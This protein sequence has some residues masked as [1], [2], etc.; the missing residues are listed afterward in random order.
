MRRKISL[1]IDGRPADLDDQALILFNYTMEDLS[2]PT[3][4][5]NSFSQQVTLPGTP[6]NNQIF[7]EMYRL[8][9]T[10]DYNSGDTGPGFNPSRKTPFAIYNELDEIL[11]SG[12]IK[13]DEVVRKR[14]AVSYKVTLYGGLGSFLF[15][16]S[17][18]EDG[19][20]RTLADLDYLG[21]GDPD[22]LDFTIDKT[23]LEQ[24]W[25][26]LGHLWSGT[27]P[28]PSGKWTVI[29][30][31]PAYNGY[32]D[33]FSPDRGIVQ[34]AGVGLTAPRDGYDVTSGYCL[35]NLANPQD[36]WA[37]KDFRSYLQRPV[38]SVKALFDALCNPDNNGGYS[39]DISSISTPGQFPYYTDIWLTLPTIPSL[40]SMKQDGTGLSLTLTS[41]A[42]TGNEIGRYD[43]VGTIPYGAM[44]NA[45][46]KCKLRFN[47]PAGADSY[48]TLYLVGD[49]GNNLAKSSV[50][51]LQMLAYG[52]DG[53]I[54]GGSSVKMLNPMERD[55]KKVATACGFIPEFATDGYE[56]VDYGQVDKVTA[57]L[58]EVATELAFQVEAQDA[59]YYKLKAYVY[60]CNSGRMRWG[61]WSNNY[62]GSGTSCRA[63]LYDDYTTYF[64]ADTVFIIDGSGNT[65]TKTDPDALRSGAMVT[66][67]MLLSSS[68]TPAEYLLSF[69]K[70]FGLY[71][72]ADT[73]DKKVTIL[74]RNDLYIDETID[75]TERVDTS[76]D[77]EI[78]P[79]LFDS[80]WYRFA[81]EGIG[82]EF[83]DEYRKV[84][85]LDYG[86]QLIDTGFD[87]NADV[88]DLLDTNVFR[89]AVTVL[90]RS[91][92]WNIIRSGGN[93]IPSPFL[94]DGNS[95]SLRDASGETKEFQISRPP[96]TATITYYNPYYNGY[97]IAN[98]TKVQFHDADGKMLDGK[99]VLL[100]LFGFDFYASFKVT[101]DLPVMT[102]LNGGK[103]CWI[104]DEGPGLLIPIFSRY[105]FQYIHPD[106]V[107]A[108]SLDFG[109]PRQLDIP[110]IVYK[111]DSTIY[112]KAWKAYLTDR[113]DVNT[114]VMRCRVHFD[115]IQVGQ[116]LLRKFFFYDNSLWVLNRISN[117][118]LTTYDPVECE[119]IKV[120]DKDNYLTGQDY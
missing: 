53:T 102:A 47:T 7:G 74:R 69:C 24:A 87:F 38:L 82:G 5:R 94:D 71:I 90:Q 9:R 37:V 81:L 97:D 34:P 108:A 64:Q 46:I 78:V 117:Y 93:F 1:Y 72:V 79:L 112:A 21:N 31:A 120:Q 58:F 45:S 96:S 68:A 63:T 11:E 26:E 114:R 4:V 67:R 33:N 107:M 54:V 75:L 29:N 61:R 18:S 16:L 105:W 76:R 88:K 43:I 27:P 84:E 42:T 40:G 8:D 106:F 103:P 36:E 99:D 110:G 111:P 39:V 100:F 10:V 83:F 20:K 14:S 116:S 98:E 48:P 3:I 15:A 28:I 23:N 109:V 77:I 89:N 115:G 49:D 92:Y 118:S 73:A 101:D 44:V 62:S 6:A 22:E 25:D 30:F 70:M 113:Y 85:G 119:F 52:S 91:R 59:S 86:I 41:N 12:Y 80:K 57:G 51:F 66:K 35:V 50:I 19:T 13:L 60:D 17:Y 95:Y 56:W 2:N 65:V 32:P 104:L 55:A